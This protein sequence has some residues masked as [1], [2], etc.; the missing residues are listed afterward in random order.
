M[1]Q[2]FYRQNIALYNPLSFEEMLFA[3]SMMRQKH[4]ALDA[5]LMDTQTSLGQFNALSQDRDFAQQAVDPVSQELNQMAEQ[6]AKEGFNNQSMSSFRKLKTQRDKLFSPTGEVG[7]AQSRLAQFQEKAKE[8]KEQYKDNPEIANFYINQLAQSPGLQRDIDGNII[9]QGLNPINNVRHYDAKEIN[10]I[11]NS[12]IDN[13]KDT[14]LQ[15]FGFQKVGN[16]SSIQDVYKQGQ[17]EGRTAS[18][19]NQILL[20]Q[21]SPEVIRSAQQYGMATMGSAEAGIQSLMNQV[22]GAASGRANQKLTSKYDIITNEEA[23]MDRQKKLEE[24][25]DLEGKAF[26][27]DAFSKVIEPGTIDDSYFDDNYVSPSAKSPYNRSFASLYN[28]PQGVGTTEEFKNRR[29]PAQY[30]PFNKQQEVV[31]K[32]IISEMTGTPVDRITGFDLNKKE[33]REILKNYYEKNKGNIR[34]TPKIENTSYLREYGGKPDQASKDLMDNYLSK[35][36]I[37]SET[38]QKVSSDEIEDIINKGGSLQVIGVYGNGSGFTKD[39]QNLGID[40]KAMTRPMTVNVV[41]QNGVIL[42]RLAA[43]RPASFYES[44]Q[45]L[46]QY[47]SDLIVDETIT[48]PNVYRTIPFSFTRNLQGQ[49]ITG[50][51]PINIKVKYNPQQGLYEVKSTD[52]SFKTFKTPDIS[53]INNGIIQ[54]INLE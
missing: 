35:Q 50:V 3:P 14:L 42:K 19:I 11:L 53:N 13:I 8:L 49:P 5:A 48:T 18:E 27:Y 9:N 40:P 10:D 44:P 51:D 39:A 45:A 4:D 22:A 43:S 16:I 20:S 34:I 15:D 54:N 36:F 21:L 17:L 30:K 29:K 41:D 52:D 12:Q 26:E 32:E 7:I 38:R 28:M 37:D 23:K 46:E 31:A 1:A 24:S 6:L 2:R 33:N 47:Q 25:S